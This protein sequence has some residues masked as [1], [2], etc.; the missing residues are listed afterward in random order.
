MRS[1]FRL[2]VFV[3][4]QLKQSLDIRKTCNVFQALTGPQ[5]DWGGTDFLLPVWRNRGSYCR[6]TLR[7][8]FLV[9]Y[10]WF[11]RILQVPR[12]FLAVHWLQNIGGWACSW[13]IGCCTNSIICPILI[14]KGENRN[15]QCFCEWSNS[16]PDWEGLGCSCRQR[17]HF[18]ISLF[19]Y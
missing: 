9:C 5:G 16:F 7:D 19:K 17:Q 1:L 15:I 3:S 13:L 8:V 14:P 6:C 12:I 11:Q 18:I 2:V 10:H 4:D